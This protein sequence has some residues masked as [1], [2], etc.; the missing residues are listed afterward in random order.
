MSRPL[1]VATNCNVQSHV[2]PWQVSSAS[3]AILWRPSRVLQPAFLI[4]EA[5]APVVGLFGVVFVGCMVAGAVSALVELSVPDSALY[6][7]GPGQ[8]RTSELRTGKPLGRGFLF[9]LKSAFSSFT[10]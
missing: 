2:R 6:S 7:H 10:L 3:T 8:A 4:L 9:A 1:V 5:F